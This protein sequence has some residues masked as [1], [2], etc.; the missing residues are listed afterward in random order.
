MEKKKRKIDVD[1]S[2]N[3]YR[4]RYIYS[5]GIIRRFFTI[6]KW[7]RLANKTIDGA[8]RGAAL[9]PITTDHRPIVNLPSVVGTVLGH[10]EKARSFPF[11]NETSEISGTS[12][13]FHCR[14]SLVIIA[15]SFDESLR[16]YELL[17]PVCQISE[18]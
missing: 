12:A 9:R 1:L 6:V 5:S 15:R 2:F 13:V 14:W 16:N 18:Y 4:D 8:Q 10:C 11:S 3:A 7:N 17:L